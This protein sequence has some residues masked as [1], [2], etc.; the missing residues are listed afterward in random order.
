MFCTIALGGGPVTQRALVGNG[1]VVNGFLERRH[2]R[3]CSIQKV[4]IREYKAICTLH[5]SCCDLIASQISK[6]NSRKTVILLGKPLCRWDDVVI[7][8]DLIRPLIPVRIP[9][10]DQCIAVAFSK[11]LASSDQLH[12][13]C[14]YGVPSL[15]SIQHV[16]ALV[17]EHEASLYLCAT[18]RCLPICCC[19]AAC[20]C[21]SNWIDSSV[22]KGVCADQLAASARTAF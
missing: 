19:P 5:L 9:E 3:G 22:A 10:T 4:V 20:L 17:P 15:Q 16:C 1:L 14:P 11:I 21:D 8:S 6:S 18:S 12:R 2:G 13:V 7:N